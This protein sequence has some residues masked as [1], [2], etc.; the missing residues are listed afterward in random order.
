M[1]EEGHQAPERRSL[2]GGIRLPAM[3]LLVLIA[4][5]IACA[6]LNWQQTL[7]GL[8]VAIVVSVT[9]ASLLY[10]PCLLIGLV[11]FRSLR[12]AHGRAWTI[13]KSAV[14]QISLHIP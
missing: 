4:L 10:V 6:V 13:W 8:V 1:N 7:S 2:S 5:A 11:R 14:E 9:I 12:E 3:V